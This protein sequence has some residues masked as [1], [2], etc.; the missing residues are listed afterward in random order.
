VNPTISGKADAG[1]LAKDYYAKE[2]TKI[3]L[4]KDCPETFTCG[5][6]SWTEHISRK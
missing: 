5:N 4:E 6:Y 2:K 3:R 1:Y